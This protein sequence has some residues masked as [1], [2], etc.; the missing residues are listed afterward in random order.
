MLQRGTV[1]VRIQAANLSSDSSS[2]ATASI[3]S[4]QAPS[5]AAS[6]RRLI[7][8]NDSTAT[9]AVRFSHLGF[10]FG[11]V[12]RQQHAV[13]CLGDEHGVALLEFQARQ[14]LLGQD[15]AGRITD[16]RELERRHG[17]L[18]RL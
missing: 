7:A 5:S 15:D 2:A 11:I 14:D 16:L 13:G 9:I 8:R 18:A 10:E 1:W 3:V 6:S 17:R 4:T 12:G